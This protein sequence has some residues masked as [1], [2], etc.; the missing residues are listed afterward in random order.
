MFVMFLQKKNQLAVFQLT[1]SWAK[2]A[3]VPFAVVTVAAAAST[4][5]PTVP[6]APHA[7][8]RS[9]TVALLSAPRGSGAAAAEAQHST[10]RRIARGRVCGRCRTLEHE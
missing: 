6:A 10:A 9:S 4:A 2:Q 3:L 1:G 7:A 5:H 8:V